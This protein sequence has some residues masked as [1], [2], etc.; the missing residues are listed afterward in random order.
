MLVALS[1]AVDDVCAGESL[2]RVKSMTDWGETSCGLP[3]VDGVR[4]RVEGPASSVDVLLMDG[5]VEPLLTDF[6][7]FDFLS[8]LTSFNDGRLWTESGS[9]RF[10]FAVL[11]V[12]GGEH[13][14]SVFK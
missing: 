13:E 9:F 10:R 3:P 1:S 4:I 11:S 14:D 8:K 6:F 12:I 5:K 7:L 2:S